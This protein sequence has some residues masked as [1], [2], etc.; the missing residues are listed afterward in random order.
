MIAGLGIDLCAVS[1]MEDLVRSDAFLKRYFSPEEAAYIRGRGAMSAASMA[2]LFAAK[3]AFVKALGDGF[4][5]IPLSDIAVAHT[6]QGAPFYAVTG[7]ARAAMD[8][9]GIRQ[10]HLSISHEREM[11]LAVCIMED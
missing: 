3:E 1:R 2:G 10:A 5:G 7:E 11:A 8:A 4:S 6:D 9:R